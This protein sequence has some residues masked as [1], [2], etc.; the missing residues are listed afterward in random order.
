ME[1]AAP[2]IRVTVTKVEKSVI[3]IIISSTRKWQD[4]GGRDQQALTVRVQKQM[5]F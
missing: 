1:E 3:I 2:V 5:T 4:M